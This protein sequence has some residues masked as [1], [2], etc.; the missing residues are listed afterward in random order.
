MDHF[1]A[2]VRGHVA[3]Q[4]LEVLGGPQSFAKGGTFGGSGTFNGISNHANA[5]VIGSA[6]EV[7]AFL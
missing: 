1:T 4:A 5:A 7:N 3:D 2:F 6:M